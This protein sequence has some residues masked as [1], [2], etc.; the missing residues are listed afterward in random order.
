[1]FLPP[2]KMD[3]E[4]LCGK[5]LQSLCIHF[6]LPLSSFIGLASAS[7]KAEVSR[8]IWFTPMSLLIG[9][10]FGQRNGWLFTEPLIS[11]R[12]SEQRRI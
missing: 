10:E 12:L 11:N 8:T 6:S 2:V 1:M 9:S 4:G 5:G 7:H 3:Q